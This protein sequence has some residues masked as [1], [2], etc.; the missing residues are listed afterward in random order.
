[1]RQRC[2]VNP[3]WLHR[4]RAVVASPVLRAERLTIPADT[5]LVRRL[6]ERPPRSARGPGGGTGRRK[7]ATVD[8]TA[9]PDL[10]DGDLVRSC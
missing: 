7:A 6:R 10:R 1:M 8:A 3:R 2:L 9:Y 4:G 5:T